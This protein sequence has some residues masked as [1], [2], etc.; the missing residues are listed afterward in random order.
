MNIGKL[1]R[2]L[3]LGG[4]TLGSGL[5]CSD[6]G[7]AKPSSDSSA[8]IDSVKAA[9]K[10]VL[11]RD[12]SADQRA[13]ADQGTLADSA[14]ASDASGDDGLIN[15]GFCPNDTACENGQLKKGFSCCWGT[16]C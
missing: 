12:S 2:V 7:A 10:G 8:V 6:D 5:A 11:A 13:Q 16:S 4:A 3:V 1:F 14:A 15:G 9:D